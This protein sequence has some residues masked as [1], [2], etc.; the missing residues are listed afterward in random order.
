MYKNGRSMH[1]LC[2]SLS[3]HTQKSPGLVQ[4]LFLY[5]LEDTYQISRLGPLLD[6]AEV[7]SFEKNDKYLFW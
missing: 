6:D 3:K 7:G 1:E 5:S 4:T 2:R